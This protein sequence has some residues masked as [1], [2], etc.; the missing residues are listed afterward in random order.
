LVAEAIHRSSARAKKPCLSVNMA[1]I[2]PAVAASEL[3]GHAKGAFTGAVEDHAGFFERADGGT[4]FLDEIGEAPVE[5]QAMLLRTLET[6]KVQPVGGRSERAVDVRLIAATDAELEALV[7]TGKF[8]APL[9]HRLAG[10]EINIPPLRERI[11]DLGRLFYH[12]LRQELERLGDTRL[13]EESEPGPTPWIPAALVGRLARY[14]WPGNVRQ[15]RNVTRQLV[16]ANRDAPVLAMDR[17]VERLLCEA[18]SASADL[19]P[20]AAREA[21]ETTPAGPRRKPSD[22]SEEELLAALKANRFRL[23]PT[24]AALRIT[25]PSLYMLIDKSSRLRKAKDVPEAEILAIHAELAGDVDAMAE[26]LEVSSRG[27]YVRLKEILSR[28]T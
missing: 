4:L 24:A 22:V 19:P 15:L 18:A 27:L 17:S 7:R 28:R 6:G 14:E 12:F 1:A 20:L 11:D 23:E 26:R 5:V 10:F 9:L 8:R 25:R 21:A 2:S 16:I 3:F 13:L